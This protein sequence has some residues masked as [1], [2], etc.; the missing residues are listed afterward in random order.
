MLW[1]PW[2]FL[3]PPGPPG[4]PLGGQYT[5]IFVANLKKISVLV[6]YFLFQVTFMSSWCYLVRDLLAMAL[7]DISWP[8][9]VTLGT[10]W[11]LPGGSIHTQ[12]RQKPNL[13]PKIKRF[14][15]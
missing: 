1:P 4:Y 11:V 5:S 9:L 6:V 7:L 3:A 13:M 12:K 8:P 10:P 14:K 15:S 2:V